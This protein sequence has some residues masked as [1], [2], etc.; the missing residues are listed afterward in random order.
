MGNKDDYLNSFYDGVAVGYVVGE[1]HFERMHEGGEGV[2][3]M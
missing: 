3:V 2:E 1:W